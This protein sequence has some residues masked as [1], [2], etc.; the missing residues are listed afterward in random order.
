MSKPAPGHLGKRPLAL[1]IER[2]CH[3]AH[4]EWLI[5]FFSALRR[6][7]AQRAA[8]LPSSPSASASEQ[9]YLFERLEPRVL[10]SADIFPLSATITPTVSLIPAVHFTL[11]VEV[12]NGGPDALTSPTKLVIHASTDGVLDAND[13][14]LASLTLNSPLAANASQFVNTELDTSKVRAPGTYTLIA[15]LDPD[16]TLAETNE[17]N[18]QLV[19]SNAIALDWRFG[20]V[21]GHTGPSSLKV[22]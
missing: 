1:A 5:S 21:P 14:L 3:Q 7:F 10:L 2:V 12:K 13:T 9:K 17:T 11:P 15:T 8:T 6:W 18:N 22:T 19:I 4:Q 20:D 16:N